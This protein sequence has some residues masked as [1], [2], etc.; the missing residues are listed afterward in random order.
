MRS[1]A[2]IQKQ[3]S[4]QPLNVLGDRLLC[5]P[6]DPLQNLLDRVKC[7]VADLKR[8][9]RRPRAF[10]GAPVATDQVAHDFAHV[11]TYQY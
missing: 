5:L 10:T 8:E 4:T 3:V 1:T 6:R 2:R 11:G 7:H 9:A